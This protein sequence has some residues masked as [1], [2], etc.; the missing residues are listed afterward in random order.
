VCS[1][2]LGLWP[3]LA[4]AKQSLGKLDGIGQTLTHPQLLLQPLQQREALRSSSLE[5]TYATPE[6]LLL[7]ELDPSEPKSEKDK[8]N[9]WLEVA[10][11][12]KAQREGYDYLEARNLNLGF[13][14]SLHGW[15]MDGVRGQDKSPGQFRDCQVYIGSDRR[16]IP[17]PIT[18]MNDCLLEFENI[19][20]TKPTKID[21]LVACYLMHYQFEAIHPFKDGNGRVGR[22]L[23]ALTTWKWCELS[24]P[25]LYMSPFFEKFKDEYI[26]SMFGISAVGDWSTFLEL[27]LRGTIAQANDSILR[28][29]KLNELK[30]TMHEKIVSGSIRM[31]TIIEGLFEFPILTIQIGRA[32]V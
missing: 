3:L 21:P 13:V 31:H 17:P 30:K 2:D 8:A 19:L 7:F 10:N 14:R 29:E 25:W 27:C 11:Y 4:Q 15:L 18:H 1:S 12:R 23:L 16:Y 24:M 28:C 5:G 32:H 9:A 20:K 6:E 22:L 26:D